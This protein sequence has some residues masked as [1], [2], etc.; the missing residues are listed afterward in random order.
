MYFKKRIDT[1][2]RHFYDLFALQESMYCFL[3]VN[4]V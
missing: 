2:I 3:G 1:L 4:V